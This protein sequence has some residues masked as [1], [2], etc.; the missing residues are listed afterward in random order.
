MRPLG[1]YVHHQ[2]AG[3]W[4]RA[5]AI[6]ARSARPCTLIGT[7]DP[8]RA[9]AAP[10]PVLRLADDRLEEGFAGADGAA[11][12]PLC[13]H[14]APLGHPGIRDRM[15]A[16]AAW[17]GRADPALMVVDVSVEI[18]LFARLL[19]VP[20][21]VV[22]LA[23]DRTD[24]AHLEA[25]RAAEA[26]VAPFPE[27][28][29]AP[30]TPD[31]VRAK[32]L[33]AG[34]LGDEARAGT[35]T[36]APADDDAIVVVLGQGG[37]RRSVADL[38]LAAEAVPERAWHVLGQLDGAPVA[39]LPPNL[40]LHGWVADAGAY[41]ARAGIVVGAAGDGVLGLAASA[42]RRFLCLPE[43]RP[44]GEQVVK[45][46]ALAERG[47]AVVSETWPGAEWPELIAGT[48]RLDPAVLGDL[49][50]PDG[51]GWLARRIE[52]VAARVDAGLRSEDPVLR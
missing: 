43:A 47:A 29:E 14:Y 17:V 41:V 30:S 48:A 40:H 52:A 42:R 36:A 18:A 19:S 9:E 28:L 31:W 44:Y 37:A 33:Y 22:R 35:T 12:R 51:L 7:L 25:F 15:A 16:L 50:R 45:A 20:T 39:T 13:L 32:T 10:G 3:H 46:R 23:G 6:A 11:H 21:I 4:Q 27:V 2:G 8:A 5:C 26:L 1:Y 38:V 49:V 24:T 34:F